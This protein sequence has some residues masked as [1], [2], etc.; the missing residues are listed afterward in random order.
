MSLLESMR[1][2]SDSTFMQVVMALVV[3]SFVGM[4][5]V[6]SGQDKSQVVASVNGTKIMSTDLGRRY[7]NRLAQLERQYNRTLGDDQ[8][9]QLREQVKQEMIEDEVVLQEARRLGLEVSDLEVGSLVL[10]QAYALD[11]DGNYNEE[12]YLR[13]LKRNQYT[14]PKFEQV[15]REDLLRMKLRRLVYMGATISEPAVREAYVESR[16]QVDIEYVKVD[17]RGFREEVQV[18]DADIDT[19]MTENEDIARETYDNDFN[20]SY[21]HPKQVRLRMIRFGIANDGVGVDVLLARMRTI[22]EE[23]EAGASF[24]D[25]VRIWSE[26]PSVAQ[27]G[28]LGLRAVS[29]FADKERFEDLEVGAITDVITSDNDV[30]LYRVE[31]LQEPMVDA[32]DDVKADIARDAIKQ[33]QVPGLA[34]EFAEEALLPGWK[35]SG[36]VPSEL[37][38]SKGLVSRK[39]GLTSTQVA[40]R[41]SF[42]PPAAML[43]ASRNVDVG[44]VLPEVYENLGSLFVG[45][46][47]ERKD[48]DMNEFELNRA[49]IEEQVLGER[50]NQFYT[51]WVADVKARASIK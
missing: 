38:L 47:I 25:M 17:P 28:D 49:G 46:L 1:S 3:V 33:E 4:Y 2:G 6:Q 12:V 41:L 18:T 44:D 51:D 34:A 26:D 16:T 20:R 29:Q 24:E 43:A 11:E 40:Q 13:F 15:L 36:K 32:F 48:A 22:R 27:N 39:N 10:S 23:V 14:R 7:R 50:R 45:Q 8:Q 5:G 9:Q 37:L 42:G 19:W 30:R 21:N 31:E 35:A